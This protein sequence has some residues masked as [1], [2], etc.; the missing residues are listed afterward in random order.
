MSDSEEHTASA[1][2]SGKVFYPDGL[3]ERSWWVNWVLAVRY[4]EVEDGTPDPEATPT[5]QPVDP[6]SRGDA[7]PCEWRDDLPDE[8][9][10]A[11]DFD[12]VT[13]W[14]GLKI[15]TDIEAPPRV[16]S[17]ELGTGIIIPPEESRDGGPVT[18]IDWDDVRDPETGEIHPTCAWALD[19]LDTYAEISQ[20][21]EG[22]HQF[23]FG[24][25]PGSHRKYL[26]HV[27][28]EAF[29]GDDRPM[30]EMYSSGRLTAMTGDHIEGTGM[31]VVGGQQLLDELCYRYRNES[32]NA[33]PT[34]SHPF[35]ENVDTDSDDVPDSETVAD[36]VDTDIEYDGDSPDDWDTHTDAGDIR[37]DAVLRGRAR[38]ADGELPSVANWKLIR[39]ASLLGKE[40]GL[41]KRD[42]KRD[43]LNIN[44]W[45]GADRRCQ[46]Q[47]NSAWRKHD[48]DSLAPPSVETLK[49]K[50]LL[51]KSYVHASAVGNDKY[52]DGADEWQAWADVRSS[53]GLDAAPW[54][55]DDALQHIATENKLYDFDSAADLDVETLPIAAHNRTLSWVKYE[56][57]PD[58]LEVDKSD[59][60]DVTVHRRQYIQRDVDAPVAGWQDIRYI[61][62][63]DR[64]LGRYFT[65]SLLRDRYHFVTTSSDG[66]LFVYD[67]DT[68]TYTTELSDTGV[69]GV[70]KDGLREHWSTHELNEITSRLRQDS[71]IERRQFNGRQQFDDPHVCVRN[72][73]LNLFTGELKP[74]S[75]EYYFVDRV[76]VTYDSDADTSVYE[77][78]FD[79][80]TKRES[81]RRTLIEMVGHALVPDANERY[82]KFLILTGDADNG[83]SVF[84]R[85]VRT[86]LNGPDGTEQNVSNV[87][88]SKMATQRFS[89]NSVYGHMANIAGEINGKKIRN[90]ASLK[91]ITGGDAVDIEPKGKGSFFDTINSTMMFAANDP[92]ILGERDKKAIASRIVPVNLP[93]SFVNNPTENDPFEKQRRPESELED[94]LLTEEA[95]SGLLRLAVEG[96]QRL[97]DN[98]GD[99]SLPES[100]MKRLRRYER[101]ADP[102]R[103]FGHKCLTNQDGDYVVKADVTTIYKEWA[104][105]QGHEL[106]S[107]INQTLHGALQ[108]MKDLNYTTS[109]PNPA[110]YSGV[111]LPLRPWNER[112][113]VVSRVT[114]TD[115]GLEYAESA[116]IV[117]R[118]DD[119]ETGSESS[120]DALA[121]RDPGYG[122]DLEA[123]VSTVNLGEYSRKAQGRLKGPNGTYI[124]YV[125]PGE[126]DIEMTAHE[127]HTVRMENVTLRT[128]DDGL[129]EAVID[130]AV[131]VERIGVSPE[132]D[133]DDGAD[134]DST[135]TDTETTETTETPDGPSDETQDTAAA[136]G[137]R[138]PTEDDADETDETDE[139]DDETAEMLTPDALD[140][141][142]PNAP[143]SQDE[144]LRVFKDTLDEFTK[145]GEFVTADE[146]ETEL[147]WDRSIIDGYLEKL[148]RESTLMGDD[149]L[150]WKYYK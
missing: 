118:D 145:N 49:S 47:I 113:R 32:N 29:V 92:P 55:T 114:L 11:T 1:V 119:D 99:V 81:D 34:P 72:G 79:D 136:D 56:W 36:V 83:K 19:E 38:K 109:R 48:A 97:E 131:T 98:S 110:D 4:D 7:T 139:T 73:V 43:L 107:S 80:W 35:G 95:L 87:K 121:S 23:V 94:E 74:H 3:K 129:L 14:D 53:D 91:D 117:E 42:V 84:F 63:G 112:K 125:V 105:S 40:A 50:G 134:G 103:Q 12:V 104:T 59:I 45:D 52:L 41:T 106:G 149:D 150:G 96:V 71:I 101:T 128:N 6:N 24:D 9:H 5:K 66:T 89:N 17:D 85:C 61:Y 82:K 58:A 127:Y 13:R 77:Q 140:K 130:D 122:H 31:D 21:G 93:Y 102:M 78:Y 90:T 26:R 147:G 44:T 18:L 123:T 120:P 54:L 124:S 27:D 116:G 69:F 88:L 86:L 141:S 132:T 144:R 148:Q 57:A 10:P 142:D 46:R 64:D 137:G 68:G 37:Y 100:P 62:E 28:D 70:I 75:P 20:S 25:I 15:G 135:E 65:E 115:E 60:D 146:L 126:N 30:F 39:Y 133:T 76:P 108:G 67:T 143:E 16:L 22:V 51:P 138:T 33:T 111:D 2:P 8:E